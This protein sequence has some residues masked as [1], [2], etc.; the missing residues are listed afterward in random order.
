MSPLG[1][2]KL[3]PVPRSPGKEEREVRL[4]TWKGR[5]ALKTEF[6]D[7]L[8]AGSHRNSFKPGRAGSA[9]LALPSPLYPVSGIP[10]QCAVGYKIT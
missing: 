8:D 10:E 5:N 2:G 6:L 7:S 4:N 3:L 1:L 9:P